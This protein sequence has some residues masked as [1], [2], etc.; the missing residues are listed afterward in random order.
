M[1]RKLKFDK[2]T[3]VNYHKW[4]IYMEA[5]LTHKQLLDVVDG[6]MRHPGGNE[7]SQRVRT[8]YRK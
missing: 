3:N 8:F 4:K 6:T 5:L 7:G 1:P 2:L